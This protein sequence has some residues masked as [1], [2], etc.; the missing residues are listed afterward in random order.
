MDRNA[1]IAGLL[2]AIARGD[3]DALNALFPLVYDELSMLARRQRR[4]WNGD[5]TLNT[6]A[7]VHEAYLKLADQKQLP[8]ESRA[9]FVA[10]AA[11][12]M[13]HILCNYARD[14]RRQKRG[15]GVQHV[16]LEPEGPPAAVELELSADQTDTLAA[17]DEALQRLERIAERQSRVVEC[18]FFGGMSVEDTAAALGMSERSVKRDWSFARAWLRREMQI[19]LGTAD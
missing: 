17:L 16:T 3:R 12:A 9:H 4:N 6:A 2:E 8:A 13:R 14:R 5:L 19:T 18:R 1:S 15:G 7:L 11:K 10:L